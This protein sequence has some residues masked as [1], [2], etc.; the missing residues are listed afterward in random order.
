MWHDEAVRW[1]SLIVLALFL[2]SA[3]VADAQVFK[4]RGKGN[5][6]TKS[7]T[8]KKS[9]RTAAKKSATTPKRSATKTKTA[10]KAPAKKGKVARAR[11][12]DLTPDPVKIDADEDYVVIEDLEDDE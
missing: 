8:A 4:P 1:L 3:T 12:S 6:T 9:G 2:G 11:P 5:K 7:A 10:K